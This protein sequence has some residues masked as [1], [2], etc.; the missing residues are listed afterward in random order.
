MKFKYRNKVH[1]ITCQF[2]DFFLSVPIQPKN[3]TRSKLDQHP[4]PLS[5]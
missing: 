2:K 3:Q 4:I 1:M 5:D